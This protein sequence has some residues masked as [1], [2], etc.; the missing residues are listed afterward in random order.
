LRYSSFGLRHSVHHAL[1]PVAQIRVRFTRADSWSMTPAASTFFVWRFRH[2]RARLVG[3][4]NRQITQN[5]KFLQFFL[6]DSVCDTEIKIKTRAVFQRVADEFLLAPLLVVLS[7]APTHSKDLLT[8]IDCLAPAPPP[9]RKARK[10][11]QTA[12]LRH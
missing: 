3:A 4:V 11:D 6:W 12:T 7:N 1:A 9:L 5:K 8:L 10:R 2:R